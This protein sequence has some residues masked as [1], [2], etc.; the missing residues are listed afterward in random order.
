MNA[1]ETL[2]TIK[3]GKNYPSYVKVEEKDKSGKPMVVEF[4][5]NSFYVGMY[6]AVHING[7]VSTQ[8]GD[9]NNKKFCAAL[10]KDIAKAIERGATVE[11][12]GVRDCKLTM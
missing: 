12:S 1:I 5:L 8:V 6:C 3:P 4:H 9:H 7:R 2:K 10:K 11:V